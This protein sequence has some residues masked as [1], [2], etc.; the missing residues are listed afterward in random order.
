MVMYYNRPLL[1]YS[2]SK[3]DPACKLISR[4]DFANPAF[5]KLGMEQVH[6]LDMCNTPE[7]YAKIKDVPLAN[8]FIGYAPR[9]VHWKTRVD[10]CVGIFRTPAFKPWTATI[11]DDYLFKWLKVEGAILCMT[12]ISLRLIHPLRTTSLSLK[13]T[14]V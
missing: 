1:N 13:Q 11:S 14:V 7:L 4:D 6:L 5:D 9:Y 2:L 8:L 10:D 12:I 3:A